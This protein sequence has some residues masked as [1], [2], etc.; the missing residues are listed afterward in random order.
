M[1]GAAVAGVASAMIK[2]YPFVVLEGVWALAALVGLIRLL[3]VE[4]DDTLPDE[5]EAG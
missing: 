4:R 1:V 5:Q 3:F 2:F